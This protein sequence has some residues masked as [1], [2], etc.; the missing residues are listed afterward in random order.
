M[1][2]LSG[3]ATALIIFGILLVIGLVYYFVTAKKATTATTKGGTKTV[4]NG[5]DSGIN[6]GDITKASTLSQMRRAV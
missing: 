3:W 1:K 6:K 4:V 5:G 2:N